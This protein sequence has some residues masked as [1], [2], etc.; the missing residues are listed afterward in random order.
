MFIHGRAIGGFLIALTL[1]ISGGCKGGTPQDG[2]DPTAV[3]RDAA[4]TNTEAAALK[5][6]VADQKQELAALRRQ[7]DQAKRKNND[8]NKKLRAAGSKGTAGER[9]HELSALLEKFR[10][11]NLRLKGVAKSLNLA[12]REIAALRGR[13]RAHQAKARKA[14]DILRRATVGGAR[15]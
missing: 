7:L 1:V 9:V 6:Q 5:T 14:L 15:R 10:A 13:E 2:G 4:V 8:L 3:E 11:E 12:Q